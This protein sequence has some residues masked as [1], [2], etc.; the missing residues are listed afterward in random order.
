MHYAVLRDPVYA[1]CAFLIC[2]SRVQDEWDTR[3]DKN[4]VLVDSD[5]DFPRLAGSFG[6]TPCE[7]C[8]TDG[9]VDCAHKT[10][11]KMI[12][13]AYDFLMEHEGE[14]FDGSEYFGD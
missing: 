8:G 7:H 12:S 10:V 11:S 9:T 1:P 3:D 14:P 13:E 4:T 6:Y 2:R 5:W